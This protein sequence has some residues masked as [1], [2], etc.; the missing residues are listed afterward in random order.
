MNPAPPVT[1]NIRAAAP[2]RPSVRPPFA[3]R[4]PAMQL[5]RPGGQPGAVLL[6][7]AMRIM[8]E[9]PILIVPYMWIGDF[10]RCHTVVRLLRTQFPSRSID[11]LTTPLVAP[12]LDY[13][14]GVRKAIVADL[15]RRRLALRQQRALARR[16]ANRRLRTGA[17]DA[18]HLE[19]G[20]GAV[21]GWNP[22]C[23][24]DSSAR[25]ASGCSTM[26]ASAS[27]RCRA[28]SIA[29]PSSPCPKA[30]PPRRNGLCRNSRCPQP[31][32]PRGCS[33]RGYPTSA[34]RR[35]HS[36]RARSV[37]PSAGRRRTMPSLPGSWS[38]SGNQV[39]VIG[40]PDER[41]IAAEIVRTGDPR[42]ARSN[43]PRPAQCRARSRRC[44]CRGIKQFRPPPRC[45]CLGYPG[46]G[47][48]RADQPLAL[49][50]AQSARRRDR[51]HRP[52]VL[53]SVPRAGL[54]PAPSPL[55]A[56]HFR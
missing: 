38:P 22:A 28:W 29:V 56:R 17:G 15:P 47:N 46:G 42:H 27:A 12:L 3:S 41:A 16:S 51:D 26:C 34:A 39:W 4:R 32:L 25:R 48:F 55:P 24:P 44:R 1:N 33:I 31:S 21:P 14:P 53:P 11:V 2:A 19:V 37:G 7:P 52:A 10:V 35:W 40:G 20:V 5:D 45:G 23:G 13:M 18:A 43:R 30:L 8:S 9:P 49:G 54:P 36:R 6:A 50:S